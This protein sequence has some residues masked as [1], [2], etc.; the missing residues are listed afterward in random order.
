MILFYC[1]L[2][3]KVLGVILFP[4]VSTLRTEDATLVTASVHKR[5]EACSG[6][7]MK[8]RIMVLKR[9]MSK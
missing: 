8:K 6:L 9:P 7:F 2:H 5:K 3:Y 1:L 4:C